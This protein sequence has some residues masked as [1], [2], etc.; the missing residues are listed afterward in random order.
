MFLRQ[1]FGYL[2][3][4]LTF[5]GDQLLS[6]ELIEI[7]LFLHMTS[8]RGRPV[9]AQLRVLATKIYYTLN[10]K[11]YLFLNTDKFHSVLKCTLQ[12]IRH[13]YYSHTRRPLLKSKLRINQVLPINRVYSANIYVISH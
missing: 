8:G 2:V 3:S 13:N 6:L 12:E 4:L 9:S 1:F 7:G 10:P 5:P 11:V